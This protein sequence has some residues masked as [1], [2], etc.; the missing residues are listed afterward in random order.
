M[1]RQEAT[2]L[3]LIA[4]H[5]PP[6]LARLCRTAVAVLH[7]HVEAGGSCFACGLTWPCEHARLA[8]H[9]LALL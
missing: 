1:E 9:N 4:D 8:E 3:V 6:E 5:Y 7:E 2:T